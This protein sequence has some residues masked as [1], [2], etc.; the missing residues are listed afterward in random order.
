MREKNILIKNI[1]VDVIIIS[2]IWG[3]LN[4][5]THKYFFGLGM[6]IYILKK[7]I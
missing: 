5:Y 3:V 2:S 4:N 6:T 1:L 7:Y